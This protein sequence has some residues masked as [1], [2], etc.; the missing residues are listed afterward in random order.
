MRSSR[1]AR[2]VFR[3]ARKGHWLL[4]GNIL[5]MTASVLWLASPLVASGTGNYHAAGI[6]GTTATSLYVLDAIVYFVDWWVKKMEDEES[7]Y[8]Q[9]ELAHTSALQ[10]FDFYFVG[11]CFFLLGVVGDFVTGHYGEVDPFWA[12]VWYAGSMVFWAVYAVLEMIRCTVDR[13]NRDKLEASAR[14]YFCPFAVCNRG[15][16]RSGAVHVNFAW[17]MMGAIFFFLGSVFY[18]LSALIWYNV[19]F[20]EPLA[21]GYTWVE[22]TAALMFILNSACLFV[23][24]GVMRWLKKV[25]TLTSRSFDQPFVVRE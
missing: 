11:N 14:F 12:Y 1:A 6:I 23:N 2:K 22:V 24:H 20:E 7:V 25:R 4:W 13:I 15:I 8:G 17:D 5:F 19:S 16:D 10:R 9:K 18:L 21:S 3:V